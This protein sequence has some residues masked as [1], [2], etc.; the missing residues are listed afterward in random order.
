MYRYHILLSIPYIV[1]YLSCLQVLA[2]VNSAVVN[3]GV[4][5][6]FQIRVF[7]FLDL[8]QGVGYWIMW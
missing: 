2:I 8:Y 1:E 7:S 6:S 4:H 5:I 3:I